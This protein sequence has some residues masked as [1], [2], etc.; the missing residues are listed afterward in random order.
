MLSGIAAAAAG[1]AG[2]KV[3]KNGVIPGLDL[4]A[5]IPALMGNKA[6]GSSGLAGT[7]V[8]VAAKSGLLNSSNIGKLTELAGSLLATSSKTAAKAGAASKNTALDGIAGL[9]AMI[10]D[11]SGSGANLGSIATLAS[12]LAKT[13]SGPKELTGLAAELGQTLSG[14]HG[15]CF[16]SG[17]GTALKA[18]DKVLGKDAKGDLFKAVLK[19]LA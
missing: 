7:L 6:G 16:K 17:A 5:I 3:S 9:A 13:A 8:S 1:L 15:I 10:A 18:L 11:N 4:A 19:G 2:D 14:S 12:K